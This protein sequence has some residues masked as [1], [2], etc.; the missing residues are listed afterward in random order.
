MKPLTK[1]KEKEYINKS[2]QTE[3]WN[4]NLVL[5]NFLIFMKYCFNVSPYF[6]KIKKTVSYCLSPTMISLI[7]NINTYN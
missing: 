3:G 1:L 7:R 4:T 2:K 6:F 5:I